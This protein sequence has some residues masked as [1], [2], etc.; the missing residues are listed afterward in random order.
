MEERYLPPCSGG[1]W[2]ISRKIADRWLALIE[3]TP[4]DEPG[5]MD[6]VLTSLGIV[7]TIGN[8]DRHFPKDEHERRCPTLELLELFAKLGRGK[9]KEC[10]V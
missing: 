8:L 1:R 2:A 5:D 4:V 9:R 6:T 3:R 10:G 7:P